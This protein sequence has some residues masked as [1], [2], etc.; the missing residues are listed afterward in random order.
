[1]VRGGRPAPSRRAARA[2]RGS[3]ASSSPIS[4]RSRATAGSSCATRR[5]RARPRH[6]VPPRRPAT[7]ADD[8]RRCRRPTAR[9]ARRAPSTIRRPTLLALLAHREH[10]VEGRPRS[11]ATTTRSAAATA[12]R[13][14]VG[15]RSDAPADGVVLA[16]PGDD[17]GLGDRHRRQPVVRAPRPRGDGIRRGR[18]GDPQRRRRRRRPRP[19]RAARQLLVGRPAAADRRSASS[20]PP[21]TAAATRPSP[22]ARRSSSGKDSLNNEY[23]GADGERHAVPPTLVI[24]AVAHVPDVDALRHRRARRGRQRRCCSLGATRPE[25]AGSHLD[26]VLGPPADARRRPRARPRCARPLPPAARGDAR[27]SRA[28]VPRRQRGRLAV[29]LAEMCIAGRL[30]RRRSRA[31]PPRHGHGAVRRVGRPLRRR[32]RARPTS[33]ALRRSART[34]ADRPCSA[35]SPPTPACASRR[36]TRSP[37]DRARAPRS[38]TGRPALG[39]AER[40]SRPRAIVVA[41][42]GTNRDG[43]AVL[44]LDLA[45][46]EP[47]SCWPASCRASPSCSTRPASSSSPAGS[48]TATPSAPGG[49]W[50][51][52]SRADGGR[53]GERLRGV[54]RRRPPVVGICNG[55]QVLT[56]TGLLPGALGHNAGGRFDCRWVRCAAEPASRCIW[57]AGL[58]DDVAL[59]DRPRRGPL[60][61]PRPRRASP[62]PARSRCATSAATRTARSPTSPASAT[63]P[64]SCSG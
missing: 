22:T 21:S 1:M 18:R 63:R 16:G 24:T 11:T 19:G 33:T 51:S 64:A 41:G 34:S 39:W 38:P 45:G 46:A 20:S 23:T 57:T 13:P 50:R 49:C 42:P 48:A 47:T 28:V 3:T 15:V 6:R 26:L 36:A 29:A 59:P 14:L 10:R 54:R 30:G 52:T 27:R 31:T 17:D 4:A 25:F 5:R 61:A 12:V 9:R 37:V 55:F 8:G 2:L 43:D 53:L 56:R 7:A 58:D 35:A 60:R 62:P 40:M 32:G 44:A